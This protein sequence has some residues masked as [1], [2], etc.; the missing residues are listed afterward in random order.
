MIGN[1]ILGMILAFIPKLFKKGIL[2]AWMCLSMTRLLLYAPRD[3]FTSFI[4]STVSFI[5]IL[6]IFIIF[7]GAIIMPERKRGRNYKKIC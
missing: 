3:T 5:N 2:G 1:F 4:V 7:L 6:T